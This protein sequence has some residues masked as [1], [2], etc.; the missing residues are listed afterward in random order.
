MNSGGGMIAMSMPS[1][2]AKYAMI[3]PDG[4][5]YPLATVLD[6]IPWQR[7]VDCARPD[8]SSIEILPI[9]FA[10][11]GPRVAFTSTG[12]VA[13]AS[14]EA[15]KITFLN[16]STGAVVRELSHPASPVALSDDVWE[17]H[18]TVQ[19]LRTVEEESGRPLV[20]PTDP[21]VPCP[22]DGN[23]PKA[24]PVVRAIV[25]DEDDRLWVESPSSVG[26]ELTGFSSAGDVL[27]T[28]P[29]PERDV[30]VAPFVRNNR[31]YI[32]ARDSLDVQSVQVYQIMVTN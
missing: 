21:S 29:M 26:F 31:L 24:L 17:A 30:R 27:G 3:N 8:R 15:F 10:D 28:V 14:R 19:W 18:P 13:I 16:S 6:S 25:V 12:A 22:I 5:L 9:P 7:S 1:P 2:E 23:R 32:V 20:L 4:T 11:W